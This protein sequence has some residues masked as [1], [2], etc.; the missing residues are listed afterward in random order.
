M[1][2]LFFFLSLPPGS[3]CCFFFLKGARGHAVVIL[4][5]LFWIF[6]FFGCEESIRSEITNPFLRFSQKTHPK[7]HFE[8]L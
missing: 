6:R 7:L 2:L 8:I 3:V 4:D 5:D 1:L